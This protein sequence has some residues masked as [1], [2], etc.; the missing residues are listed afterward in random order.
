MKDDSIQQKGPILRDENER[1]S[2]LNPMRRVWRIS[3]RKIPRLDSVVKNN[4]N[5][6]I[7]VNPADILKK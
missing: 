2:T 4:K 1:P 6:I 7:G 3:L 5:G